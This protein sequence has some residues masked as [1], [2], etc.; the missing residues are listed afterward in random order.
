MGR[1]TLEKLL[2]RLGLWG[3]TRDLYQRTCNRPEFDARRARREL[4]RRFVPPG[5]LVFDVGANVGEY[6]GTFLRLGARV[7]AVEPNPQLVDI[8]KC[9]HPRAT[10]EAIALG[11]V[12]GTAELHIGRS[13]VHSTLSKRW[14][15]TISGD[16]RSGARWS[17]VV[18][19]E[20]TTF[21]DLICRYGEPDF[22]KIDVEGYEAD[23]LSGLS[24]ALKGLSFE[25]QRAAPDLYFRTVEALE[26]LGTYRFSLCTADYRLRE[27][28]LDDQA[29]LEELDRTSRET[30]G[31][32]FA[33]RA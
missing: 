26:K 10:I 33:V 20:V 13:H 17:G 25:F 24:V 12:G 27:P 30:S 28:W 11:A 29:L 9:R 31:D 1:H 2:C 7:I 18:P 4:F 19:V 15:E 32:V 14:V 5:A 22:A 23:V 16:E 8:I 21:D 6:T 3:V